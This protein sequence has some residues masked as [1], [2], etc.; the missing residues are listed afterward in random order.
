MIFQREIAAG[1]YK[2]SK[3]SACGGPIEDFHENIL[4][5]RLVAKN[6]RYDIV[7]N[8]FKNTLSPFPVLF[9][10]GKGDASLPPWQF[11][12][13]SPGRNTK[14]SHTKSLRNFQ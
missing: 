7:K 10:D 12:A 2:S 14:I 4:I 5:L 8:Y 1:S 6:F 13:K 11:L 3:C 9:N